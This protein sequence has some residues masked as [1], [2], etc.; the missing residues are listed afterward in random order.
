MKIFFIFLF[1][2]VSLVHAK[3]T[4]PNYDFNLGVIENFFPSKTIEDIKKLNLK[5]ETLEDNGDSKLLKTKLIKKDYVLD[6]YLQLKK[7]IIID[8]YIRMP[9]YFNH[10]IFLKE[11]QTKWKKQD[12]FKNKDGSSYYVWFNRDNL[13]I[14]YQ[15][16]C[17][18]TCFPMFIEFVKSGDKS[19]PPLYKKFNDNL[20]PVSLDM[21]TSK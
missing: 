15:G 16:S 21:P 11:L 19:T 1:S 12:K 13:N 9:Q 3:I 7:D 20:F 14:L 8:T 2:I 6:I 4:P 17:S 10:D 5:I 18:I